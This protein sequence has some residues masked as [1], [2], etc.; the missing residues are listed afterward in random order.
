MTRSGV[1]DR[2]LAAALHGL[3]RERA[4]WGQAM[5]AEMAAVDSR[6]ER[7]LFL[8]GCLRVVVLRPGTWS[9]PRLVRFACCAVLAVTVGG[10]AT[11]IATSSNP[12]QKLREGGWILALL[13]GSYL[14]GFLAIT[15]R[16]CAATA[17]VLLIGGG[18]GLASVGAAAVLMFAIPPV[19]RSIGSTVL[20]VA[21]AA[22][23][24]AALAQRPHDD[25]AASLAGLFAATVGSLGIVILVDIIAS[26]GPAEL[27]PIVVPTTLSP[28]MQISES[29]IELV[30][31]YI[32]LLFLGAVMGLLLGIT[33]L[34]TRSRLA[35]GWRPRG[36][37]P[38]AGGPTRRR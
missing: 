18:A 10:I 25:R 38:P 11:A 1:S 5:R 29:R 21:L 26:A 28:A 7:W 6:S 20:L 24:A 27:I 35:T 32:G 16:R 33:A 17:R 36:E 19:P 4:E 14:F 8:L 31:P 37:T 12:G 9:T 2:L 34:L 30:D 3:P 13:I 23:G 15:S 22:L